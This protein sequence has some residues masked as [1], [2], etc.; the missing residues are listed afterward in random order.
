VTPA[1]TYTEDGC[2]ADSLGNGGPLT[3]VGYNFSITTVAQCLD[4]CGSTAQNGPYK[5]GGVEANTCFCANG[6][7]TSAP[8]G[9]C[10]TPCSGDPSHMCGGS[11]KKRKTRKRNA[12]SN[13]VIYVVRYFQSMI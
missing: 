13:I 12:P 5:Y 1:G 3:S 6:L 4:G 11:S 8:T 7:D 2:Y 9:T 10:D